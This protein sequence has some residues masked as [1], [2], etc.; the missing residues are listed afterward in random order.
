M[1]RIDD[2]VLFNR[3]SRHDM[4]GILQVRLGEVYRWSFE[5]KKK[6]KSF[7]RPTGSSH[8]G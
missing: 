5:E 4:D 3:L 2:M 8:R 7:T 6:C 1:N